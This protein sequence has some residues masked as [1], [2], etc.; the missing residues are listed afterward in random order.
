MAV[1]KKLAH[2]ELPQLSR[3]SRDNDAHNLSAPASETSRFVRV[4]STNCCR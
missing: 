1:A 3:P 4:L 2:N